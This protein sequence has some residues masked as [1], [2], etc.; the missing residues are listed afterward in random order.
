M[1]MIDLQLGTKHRQTAE[2]DYAIRT[3][4]G[5]AKR[6]LNKYYELTDSAEAYRIAMGM[7]CILVAHNLTA[8]YACTSSAS[9]QLQD[10]LLQEGWL[11]GK[12]D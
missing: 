5:I 7:Y 8:N 12:L 6:T 10:G 2:Y 1:D 3:A 9:S 11:G 4:M